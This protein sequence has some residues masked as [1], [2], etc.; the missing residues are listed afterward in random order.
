VAFNAVGTRLG[1]TPRA[2]ALGA[3]FLL[4]QQDLFG[5]FA[6]ARGAVAIGT[7]HS[8]KIEMTSMIETAVDQPTRGQFG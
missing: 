1:T 5:P 2:V 7:L 3:H 4:G 6:H 8:A